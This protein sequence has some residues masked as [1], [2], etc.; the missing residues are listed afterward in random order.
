MGK[1][2]EALKDAEQCILYNGNW[3]KGYTRKGAALKQ[4]G[5]C[6]YTPP[7]HTCRQQTEIIRHTVELALSH[8]GRV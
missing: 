2:K 3:D 7:H 5:D 6:P 8:S 4:S 1:V